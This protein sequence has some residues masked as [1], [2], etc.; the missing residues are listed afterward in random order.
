MVNPDSKVT[1]SFGFV[2]VDEKTTLVTQRCRDYSYAL[3]VET[4]I[5]VRRGVGLSDLISWQRKMEIPE[6]DRYGNLLNLSQSCITTCWRWINRLKISLS[7]STLKVLKKNGKI[8]TKINFI[9]NFGNHTLQRQSLTSITGTKQSF[10]YRKR[11]SILY[12]IFCIKP[13]C[14]LHLFRKVL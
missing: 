13:R 10:I 6:F 12:T 14:L 9:K 1:P 8:H 3:N 7:S 5:K 11:N 2:Y 4:L